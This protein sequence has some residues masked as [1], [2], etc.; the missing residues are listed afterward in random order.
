[1]TRLLPIL[2]QLFL[3]L[4]GYIAASLAASVFI[5]L[6]FFATAGIRTEDVPML[7]GGGFAFSIPLVALVIAWFAFLPAAVAILAA[8]LFSLRGW[9][10]YALAGGAV[11]AA[12]AVSFVWQIGL[13]MDSVAE[14]L[15]VAPDVAPDRPLV[16][17]ILAAGIA[18][19]AV[20]GRFAGAWKGR[21]AAIRP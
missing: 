11:G 5:H 18:Y 1:M 6:M 4:A 7:L 20:A 16:L 12:V 15:G 3:I 21:P 2:G 13:G 17:L 19:W 14:N 9:L 10:S 8:E